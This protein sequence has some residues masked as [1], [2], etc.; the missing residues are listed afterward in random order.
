[1]SAVTT[2]GLLAQRDEDGVPV[3]PAWLGLP[4]LS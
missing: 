2:W 4:D 3:V 1:M